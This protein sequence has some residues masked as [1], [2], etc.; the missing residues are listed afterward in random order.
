MRG[1]MGI[2]PFIAG[3]FGDKRCDIRKIMFLCGILLNGLIIPFQIS[4]FRI[5][6]VSDECGEGA[7]TFFLSLVCVRI[8]QLSEIS[9]C[10]HTDCTLY[11]VHICT[12]VRCI[13]KDCFD[14]CCRHIGVC[15]RVPVCLYLSLVVCYNSLLYLI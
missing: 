12:R 8:S 7:L 9:V 14:C 3:C 4:H 13:N 15:M 5:A 10:T 6:C 1:G 11:T 2:T